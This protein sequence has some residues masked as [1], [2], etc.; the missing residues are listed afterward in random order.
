MEFST[1]EAC[2]LL[3]VDYTALNE[4]IRNGFVELDITAN[5]RGTRSRISFENL[6]T[7]RAFQIM[8]KAGITRQL[9]CDLIKR[10]QS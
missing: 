8:V 5:G 3:G 7:I 1:F 6:V 4:W 9:A 10:V 2:E